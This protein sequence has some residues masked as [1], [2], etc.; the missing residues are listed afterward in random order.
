MS[1]QGTLKLPDLPPTGLGGSCSIIDVQYRYSTLHYITLQYSTLPYSTVHYSTVH[2]RLDLH[3]DPSGPSFDLVV[4]FP[5]MLGTIPL[6]ES[7][8]DLTSPYDSQFGGGFT[9]L[10]PP[11]EHFK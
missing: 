9:D 7:I 5:I 11:P 3:V 6:Q 2:Y 8:P 1:L 10:P 4:K